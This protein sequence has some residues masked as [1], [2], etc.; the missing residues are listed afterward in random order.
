M[1]RCQSLKIKNII[2]QKASYMENLTYFDFLPE[3]II[4]II[5]QNSTFLS[6]VNLYIVS[7]HVSKIF[8]DI[9]NWKI[10][11]NKNFPHI[12]EVLKITDD[13][14]NRD[15]IIRLFYYYKD[16]EYGVRDFLDLDLTKIGKNKD[17]YQIMEFLANSIRGNYTNWVYKLLIA[18]NY[19]SNY[20][21]IIEL[22]GNFQIGS[23]NLDKDPINNDIL[24]ILFSLIYAGSLVDE[25]DTIRKYLINGKLDNYPTLNELSPM[26]SNY[27]SDGGDLFMSFNYVFLWL[28][29]N[30]PNVDNNDD[31]QIE[32][33]I[34]F[35]C[36]IA[37]KLNKSIRPI[38]EKLNSENINTLYENVTF[39]IRNAD[40]KTKI[41]AIIEYYSNQV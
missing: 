8:N 15:A 37:E 16:N 17:I 39:A 21:R 7:P 25:N 38:I 9:V 5:F 13:V 29:L 2:V 32:E 20:S 10:L 26:I 11:L 36:A 33:T 18:K 4:L 40:R 30:D 19:P 6:S 3:D 31:P 14:N 24:S 1:E 27:A 41:T 28:Y 34:L 23:Y 22:I 35:M 12:Y